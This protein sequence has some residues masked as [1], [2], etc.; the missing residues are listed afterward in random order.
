MQI[1]AILVGLAIGT[2]IAWVTCWLVMRARISVLEARASQLQTTIDDSAEMTERF[3][4]VAND[5]LVESGRQIVEMAHS[6]LKDTQEASEKEL[7]N[8]TDS[9]AAMLD[10]IKDT[11][12]RVEAANRR[13]ESERKESYGQINERLMSLAGTQVKIETETSQLVKALRAPQVR[14]RWGEMQLQRV[15]E[16]AGMEEHCDFTEQTTISGDDGVLRPDL[17]VTLPGDKPV[18]VDAKAPLS[19]YL[20]S[21]EAEDETERRNLAKDHARHV[22]DHVKK[23]GDKSYARAAGL[24][25]EFVVLFLPGE[26]FFHAALQADPDLIQK[27]VDHG[28]LIATP[29]TLIALL[30]TIGFGWG[31]ERIAENAEEVSALGREMN[32]RIG[33]FVDHFAKLGKR[34]NSAVGAYND[35]VGS[36]ES[37]V[38]VSARKFEELGVSSKT[39]LDAPPQVDMRARNVTDASSV[40]AEAFGLDAALD[41][42]SD[43]SAELA[44]NAPSE[45]D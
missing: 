9:V 10:P 4:S 2:A 36:L 5:A 41:I 6:S 32:E 22:N 40:E 17:I 24:A 45:N 39:S 42:G 16:L 44:L 12:E 33:K 8:K 21:L 43:L 27:A 11:L 38:L 35:S 30:Q 20:D 31:Q 3:R 7:A 28:V 14:G 29:T 34:L 26:Q 25:P 18:I 37:R 23:L 1:A 19:A 13:L 15:V